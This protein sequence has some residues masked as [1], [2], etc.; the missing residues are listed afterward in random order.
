M[1]KGIRFSEALA[2]A[3]EHSFPNYY[4]YRFQPS[5]LN[6]TGVP[7]AAIP[8]LLNTNDGSLIRIKGNGASPWVVSGSLE[9]GYQLS[10]DETPEKVINIEFE[11]LPDWMQRCTADGVSME[12]VGL[13]LHGDMA[14]VN[15][16]PGCEYFLA[17]KKDGVSMRCTFCSYGA[18]NERTDH[19]GQISDTVSL[20]EQ[21]Y[22]R[23]QE[24]LTAACQE[25]KIR[26]IYLVGGSML[27]RAKEGER[28]IEVAQYVQEVNQHRIPIT[29]GSGALMDEHLDHLHNERLVDNVCFN[30]EV[31]SKP[32]FTKICPGKHTYV[33][34]HSWIASLEKAV[35]LWGKEHVYTAMVGGVEL[36]PEHEL[37]WQE[38][39]DLAIQGAEDLCSRGIIPIYSLYWPL[40]GRNHPDYMS[41]LR[42]YFEQLNLGYYEIRRRFG[43]RI[44]EGFMCHRC[45]YMQLECDVDRAMEHADRVASPT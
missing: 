42:N 41:N 9:A 10:S 8:Y 18:P 23:L 4:P 34:Y 44:W 40:A 25:S 38:A 12:K 29:C 32:L 22:K 37:S 31:W 20:P 5:E 1:F 35:S 33:G 7:Q 2:K 13:S 19:L 15:I 39:S 16:A 14:V 45:A 24:S 6:P 26:H 30:L 11:P 27:D 36:E 21:T 3:A 43:L 17:K 28:F